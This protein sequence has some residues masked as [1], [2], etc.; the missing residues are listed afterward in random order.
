V[1]TADAGLYTLRLGP[2]PLGAVIS[3]WYISRMFAQGQTGIEGREVQDGKGPNF[4]LPEL[5]LP[6]SL[7]IFLT[8]SLSL[9]F[10]C[11]AAELICAFFLHLR[12][13]YNWPFTAPH[14][15]VLDFKTYGSKFAR[16]HHADFFDIEPDYPFAYPAPVA[17]FYKLMY[18][19]PWRRTIFFFAFVAIAALGGGFLVAREA[20]R[21][22]LRAR[23][24]FLFCGVTVLV[25]YP[26][27]FEAKQGN[28]E[29]WV[30]VFIASGVWLFLRGRGYSSAAC[31][32]IAASMKIFPLIYLGLFLAKNRWKPFLF[33][34]VS[35]IASTLV[36]LWLLVPDIPYAWYRIQQ[37]M[38]GFQQKIVL[39]VVLREI[40]FDH[41]LF[42][43]VKRLWLAS[44]TNVS[45]SHVL[46]VYMIVAATGGTVLFFWRIRR[47]PF[48]NQVL[49][50]AICSILLPPVSYDYTLIHLY[51][52][53][54]LLMFVAID[55][56]RRSVPLPGLTA[57]LI[58]LAISLAPLSELILGGTRFG[59]QVRAIV[60][61]LLLI[62]ALIYP[63]S[64]E[65]EAVELSPIKTV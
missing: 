30:W 23:S 60:L 26:L 41:S 40:G 45:L 36:S 16:Y 28:L 54:A 6:R 37:G 65:A 13:P 35:A 31:F 50:L 47:L 29:L 61:F 14:E 53:L 33:G 11:V 52:P 21:R 32:G 15:I 9:A 57:T 20:I 1:A 58:L 38:T 25:S 55:A 2:R 44:G 19:I 48:A 42:S 17:V 12:F 18:L 51:A 59:G 64:S 43:V 5:A 63:L 49:I 56:A 22:G 27:L 39:T 4:L 34:F 10:V 3:A 62:V 46:S 8:V 7:R 24:A